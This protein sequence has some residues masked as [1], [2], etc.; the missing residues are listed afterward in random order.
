MRFLSKMSRPQAQPRLPQPIVPLLQRGIPNF[1]PNKLLV[2]LQKLM[3]PNPKLI[4][5]PTIKQLGKGI[6]LKEIK[7]AENWHGKGKLRL[8][9]LHSQNSILQA[10]HTPFKSSAMK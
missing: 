9:R 4:L 8:Q 6:V 5:N 1:K 3:N 2:L 7:K 10:L